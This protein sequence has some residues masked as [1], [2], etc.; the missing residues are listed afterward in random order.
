MWRVVCGSAKK[1]QAIIVLLQSLNENKKAEKA[2]SKLTVTD[3][4]VDDGLEKLL[5]KLDSTFKLE[6]TQKSNNVYKDFNTF[7]QLQD[8]SINNNYLLEFEHLNDTM[9][10]FDLKLPDVL[11]LKLLESAS[12]T[13][14]EKQM[15]LTIV[16]D[17]KY[18]IMRLALKRILL[19]IP[20]KSESSF[21]INN[22]QEE[23][24]FTKKDKIKI[25]I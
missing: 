9:I 19:N 12:F 16:D 17:L 23:L 21:E 14:N 5:E 3:L 8:M 4:N 2:G 25:K 11:Y 22:K 1:E 24:L 6:K 7:Q 20:N 13:A 18:D 10:Q 15:A